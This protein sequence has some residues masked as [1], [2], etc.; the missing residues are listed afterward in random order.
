MTRTLAVALA[1]VALPAAAH[2]APDS[3]PAGDAKLA[4][5]PHRLFGG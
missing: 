3:E 4:G 5:E 1:L 2:A